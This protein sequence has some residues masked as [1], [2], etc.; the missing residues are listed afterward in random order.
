M[1]SESNLQRQSGV[2]Y[3]LLSVCYFKTALIVASMVV[4]YR[5]YRSDESFRGVCTA[6][7]FF[8]DYEVQ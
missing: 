6:D 3:S 8:N 5:I 7:V 1:S 4:I 2:Q